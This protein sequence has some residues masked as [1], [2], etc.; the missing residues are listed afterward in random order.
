MKSD[1]AFKK[2]I[3]KGLRVVTP[4]LIIGA[5]AFAVFTGLE[6]ITASALRRV[7]PKT[8]YFPGLGVVFL[9]AVIYAVGLVMNT[10]VVQRLSDC[11]E[12]LMGRI[13]FIKSIYGAVQ[14]T[15]LFL[16]STKTKKFN[17][18]VSLTLK[19][20]GL[21]LIGFVTQENLFSMPAL[22]G[23]ADMVIV[24]LPMSYQIGGY[25]ALVPRSALEP[26]N[27]SIEDASRLV[28]TAGMSIQKRGPLEAP[29]GGAFREPR[30]QEA[31]HVH[32]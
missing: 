11:W 2:T 23:T 17:K 26:V 29:I 27:M 9:T 32:P 8:F 20:S 31:T 14:D 6:S 13:P 16:S 10:R 28:F 22:T 19:E 4:V 25:M 15:V 3:A 5:V 1:Y 21:R 24:Y 30:L 7:L 18:V 12:H